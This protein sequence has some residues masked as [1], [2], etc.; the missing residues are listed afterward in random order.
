MGPVV[1]GYKYPDL[2][3]IAVYVEHTEKVLKSGD[4]IGDIAESKETTEMVTRRKRVGN[5][6]KDC[7]LRSVSTNYNASSMA[8]HPDGRPVEID[9]ALNFVEEETI[10]RRDVKDGY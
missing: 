8:F 7:Y 10:S 5:R 6:I 9:L 3:R 1:A 4:N 2:F